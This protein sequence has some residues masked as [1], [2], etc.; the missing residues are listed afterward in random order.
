MT[1][2]DWQRLETWYAEAAALT[3]TARADFVRARHAEDAALARE[4]DEL[5]AA[6]E[7]AATAFSQPIVPQLAAEPSRAGDW[8]LKEIIGEG[9][10]GVVRRAQRGAETGAVKYVHAGY[11]SGA[12]RARFLKERTILRSLDHPSIARLLDGGV[13]EAGRPYFVMEYIEG[14]PW[15]EYLAHERPPL[16]ERARLFSQLVEAVSYLH[17]RAV[18][19]GDLKPANVMVTAGGQV[20]LLDFGAARLL[21]GAGRPVE[22]T[23]TRAMLTPGWAS[24]E[25]AAGGACTARSD[26]YSLG[27]LLRHALAGETD[28]D[29]AAIAA[30]AA[31]EEPA[32]RYESAMALREDVEAFRR[33]RPVAARRGNRWYVARKFVRR[34]RA[35]LA[36]A[37]VLAAVAAGLLIDRR[38]QRQR[39][40]Q[41]HTALRET[42]RPSEAIATLVDAAAANS[43]AAPDANGRLD[44]MFL[45]GFA[46]LKEGKCEDVETALAGVPESMKSLPDQR[47]RDIARMRLALL[48]GLC[49]PRLGRRAEGIDLLDEGF[50]LREQLSLTEAF[51]PAFVQR[52]GVIAQNT[53]DAGSPERGARMSH[54]AVTEALRSG[55]VGEAGAVWLQMLR[56]LRRAGATVLLEK[57]CRAPLP[58]GLSGVAANAT[59]ICAG[60]AETAA[61]NSVADWQRAVNKHREDAAKATQAGQPAEARRHLLERLALLEKLAAAEPEVPRWKTMLKRSRERLHSQGGDLLPP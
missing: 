39:Q 31:R 4:L 57:T 59:R 50:R 16:G 51:Q 10:L 9:G 47:S 13:D 43:T 56:S 55:E 34:H 44:M 21:D 1:P 3:G 17:G 24:P 60:E 12:F 46:K 22:S 2:G 33:N 14:R 37:A 28:A 53:F 38:Q 54:W 11:D 41:L 29:L 32:E 49:L 58:A 52:L 40:Q 25:Q 23:F 19:H 36:L 61:P 27:L 18:V 8:E 35:A 7:E 15:D 20:K 48:R 30:Q 42:V 45:L 5:V 26:I 6:Q